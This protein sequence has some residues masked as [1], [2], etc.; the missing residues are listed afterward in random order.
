[1]LTWWESDR[2]LVVED[3]M[4][5]LRISLPEAL[6]AFVEKQ[7]AAGGFSSTSEYLSAL[8]RDDQIRKAEA[9]L[10]A[11]LLEGLESGPAVEMTD[12][13][14]DE[15]RRRFDERHPDPSAS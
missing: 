13:D 12:D 10:E 7:V 2:T 4:T 6:Q 15:L 9:R 3:G 14:W 8:I 1:M 5:E 11:L